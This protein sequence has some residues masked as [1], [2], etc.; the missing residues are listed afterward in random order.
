MLISINMEVKD[1]G[2]RRDQLLRARL[3][4]APTTPASTPSPFKPAAHANP[5]Q[6]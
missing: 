1:H 3:L 2:A 4:L 5:W 6:A